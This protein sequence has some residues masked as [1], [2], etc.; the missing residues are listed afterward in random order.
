V[1]DNVVWNA[2]NGHEATLAIGN[3]HVRRYPPA[4]M[5]FAGFATPE[6]P[7]LDALAQLLAP[8]D[9]LWI[10][11]VSIPDDAAV[12]STLMMQ[13]RQYIYRHSTV[14]PLP[15]ERPTIQRLAETDLP[16]AN[17]LAA[18]TGSRLLT[19]EM[20]SFWSYW[21]IPHHEELIA[22][23]GQETHIG[24]FRELGNIC[25]APEYTGRGL[26]T[27]LIRWHIANIL[28][29]DETPILYVLETNQRA[30]SLYE[31]LGFTHRK[32]I[33]FQLLHKRNR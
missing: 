30:I 24:S 27:L 3:D 26:A 5:D 16:A 12:V 10:E 6:Q 31:R 7:A 4:Y 14:P 33:H 25:T 23:A 13:C 11:A 9:T 1:L 21:G 19:P 2:L 15:H 28:S 18:R 22:M 29:R 8:G 32:D 20:L 17:R